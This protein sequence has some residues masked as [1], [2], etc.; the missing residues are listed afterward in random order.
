MVGATRLPL[1]GHDKS[2][3]HPL[4]PV[5]KKDKVG[6]SIP[7]PTLLQCSTGTLSRD[8]NLARA[9]HFSRPVDHAVTVGFAHKMEVRLL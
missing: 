4:A 1:F 9:E 7:F 2:P 3:L 8:P 5:F 6:G